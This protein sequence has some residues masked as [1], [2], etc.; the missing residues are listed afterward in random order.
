MEPSGSGFHG[1]EPVVGIGKGKLIEALHCRHRP[2]IRR[3]LVRAVSVAQAAANELWGDTVAEMI[4]LCLFLGPLRSFGL[5]TGSCFALKQRTWRDLHSGF[6]NVAALSVDG[7]FSQAL[8]VHRHT[9]ESRWL[10]SVQLLLRGF[11]LRKTTVASEKATSLMIDGSFERA[12]SSIRSSEV[13]P[14]PLS[15]QKTFMCLSNSA[16]WTPLLPARPVISKLISL[17]IIFPV[18]VQRLVSIY[19]AGSVASTTLHSTQS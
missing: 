6:S 13:L 4:L 3:R 14:E 16:F 11:S 10:A 8:L 17:V 9:R 18:H 15:P 12:E 5:T 7:Y 19:S 2:G 1:A